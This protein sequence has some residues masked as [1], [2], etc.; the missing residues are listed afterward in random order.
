MATL[1]FWQ[2][3]AFTSEPFKGNPCAV[4]FDA[5]ALGADAMQMIA[6]EMNLSETVFLMAPNREGADYHARIFTPITE[7]PFAGRGRLADSGRWHGRQGDR[8]SN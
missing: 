3:D 4:V 7:L 5:E 2:V 6:R 8:R 1:D